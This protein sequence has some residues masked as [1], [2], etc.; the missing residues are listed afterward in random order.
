VIGLENQISVG[1]GNKWSRIGVAGIGSKTAVWFV[2]PGP[3]LTR[4]AILFSVP[5]SLRSRFA[6][7]R[8]DESFKILRWFVSA[9]SSPEGFQSLFGNFVL[10]IFLR[11]RV[12]LFEEVASTALMDVNDAVLLQHISKGSIDFWGVLAVYPVFGK[13]HLLTPCSLNSCYHP[14]PCTD[15]PQSSPR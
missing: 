7:C 6:L 9:E 4:G 1:I 8:I 10:L 5:F 3:P 13:C 2:C 12:L 15:D 14:S 11:S